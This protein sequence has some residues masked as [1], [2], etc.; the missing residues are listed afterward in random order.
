MRKSTLIV[1][2][3]TTLLL[4]SAPPDPTASP[5]RPPSLQKDLDALTQRGLTYRIV[6]STNCSTCGKGQW[7]EVYDPRTALTNRFP[8]DPLLMPRVPK[9]TGLPTLT[10]NLTT[11][12]TN[13]YSWKYNLHSTIPV[14]GI[15]GYHLLSA[16]V[17]NNGRA[18]VY[19]GYSQIGAF[20]LKIYEI[21]PPSQWVLRHTFPSSTGIQEFIGDVD[22]DGLSELYTR[23]SGSLQS[24][25]QATPNDYPIRSKLQFSL[26]DATGIPNHLADMNGDSLKEL[27]YRGGE[28]DSVIV[29]REKCYVAEY[30]GLIV[31]FRPIWSRQLPQ[32]CQASYCASNLQP[33]DFD[34]DGKS[35]V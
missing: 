11:I 33:G 31:N 6:D 14:S 16:D 17:N 2:L 3:W 1:A 8:L 21:A 20:G 12:D 27:V 10:I 15:E 26:G 25:D 18:E 9:Y 22:Q 28:P 19:G 30:D 13:L 32:E 7:V 4:S 34:F 35:V 23:Y 29:T 24:Y 5:I